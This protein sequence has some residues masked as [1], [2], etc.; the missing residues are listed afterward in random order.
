L[1]GEPP[2]SRFD[3]GWLKLPVDRKVQCLS[4]LP[5]VELLAEGSAPPPTLV[6]SRM[7]F[8]KSLLRR[9]AGFVRLPPQ[10]HLILLP[11]PARHNDTSSE[12]N[13]TVCLELVEAKR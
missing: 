10:L 8:V 12:G 6:E 3:L 13:P 9:T 2:I 1:L 4:V 11:S 5:L 7:F